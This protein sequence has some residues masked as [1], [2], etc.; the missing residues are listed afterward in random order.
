MA[1]VRIPAQGQSIEEVPAIRDYLAAQGIDY[2]QVGL[3]S[4]SADG[5]AA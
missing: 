2:A 1:L 3:P 4:D 5:A